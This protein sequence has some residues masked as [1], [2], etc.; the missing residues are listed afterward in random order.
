MGRKVSAEPRRGKRGKK[1]AQASRKSDL[2]R[3]IAALEREV[4][5]K[6]ALLEKIRG[7]LP[8]N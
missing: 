5:V 2:G 1:A 3:Q 4:K 7:L 6:M 8:D